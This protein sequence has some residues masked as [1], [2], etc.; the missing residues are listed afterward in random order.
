MAPLKGEKS[1]T[2]SL[3]TSAE[4]IIIREKQVLFLYPGSQ[5]A[6]DHLSGPP[7][8]PVSVWKD[9]PWNARND[10]FWGPETNVS[11]DSLRR[12]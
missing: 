10:F 12:E 4:R 11:R 5:A 8:S 9:D 1:K 6:E 2:F 3:V 7:N